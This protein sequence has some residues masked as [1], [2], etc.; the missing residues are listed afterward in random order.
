MLLE[1]LGALF[2][3]FA[4]LEKVR[5]GVVIFLRFEAAPALVRL[6]G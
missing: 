4:M 5:N 3:F 6:L 1:A 2:Y